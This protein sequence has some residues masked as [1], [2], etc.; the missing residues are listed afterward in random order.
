MT[1]AKA[2]Y[3]FVQRKWH[4]FKI[5]H[6]PVFLEELKEARCQ[7]ARFA[8]KLNA[9]CQYTQPCLTEGRGEALACLSCVFPLTFPV[10]LTLS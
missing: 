4:G 8:N 2:E 7:T 10:R 5:G 9:L 1:L 6:S 3:E